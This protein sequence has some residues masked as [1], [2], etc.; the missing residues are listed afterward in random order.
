MSKSFRFDLRYLGIKIRM[1]PS[2]VMMA[3][4]EHLHSNEKDLPHSNEK[5]SLMVKDHG[6]N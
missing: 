5:Y 6:K 4:L 2:L 1:L 3:V